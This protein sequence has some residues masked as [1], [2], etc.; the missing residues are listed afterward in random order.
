MPGPFVSSPQ[1]SPLHSLGH[2][3]RGDPLSGR[4]LDN[5]KPGVPGIPNLNLQTSDSFLNRLPVADLEISETSLGKGFAFD[6]QK[7][8][9]PGQFFRRPLVPF[10]D[11][12]KQGNTACH[13][14]FPQ[15]HPQRPAASA[16]GSATG[17]RGGPLLLDE[18]SLPKSKAIS[19]TPPRRDGAYSKL[20]GM[21]SLGG[22]NHVSLVES[23]CQQASDEL[24]TPASESRRRL[25]MAGVPNKRQRDT[26]EDI[27]GKLLSKSTAAEEI[28]GH[29]LVKPPEEIIDDQE[30]SARL[31]NVN[32]SSSGSASREQAVG[33]K[34]PEMHDR[35]IEHLFQRS[36]PAST[37]GD[38]ERPAHRS[39]RRR[40]QP[41]AHGPALLR[42][43]PHFGVLRRNRSQSRTSN[44]SKKRSEDHKHRR[45]TEDERKK[46]AMQHVAQYWN[47]CIQISEDEKKLAN[48]EIGNLQHQLQRQALKLTESRSILSQKQQELESAESQKHQL[49]EEGFRMTEENKRLKD[50]AQTLRGQLS[51]SNAQATK[52]REKHRQIR[53]KLNEAIQEQQTLFR[54]SQA[55][56]EDSMAGFRREK[57]ERN[58]YT[59]KM[60]QALETSRKKREEMKRCFDEFRDKM[61]RESR[62]REDTILQL[63]S[64]IEEQEESL[65]HERN[66]TES[67]RRQADLQRDSQNTMATIS[68]NME[69]FLQDCAM[70]YRDQQGSA[71][72]VEN[73][74]E[75]HYMQN[76]EA[77]KSSPVVVTQAIKCMEELISRRV[78]TVVADLATNQGRMEGTLLALGKNCGIQVQKIREYLEYQN[79]EVLNGQE[80][81]EKVR[82][83]FRSSLES[84]QSE[85][86]AARETCQ[87]IKQAVKDGTQTELALRQEEM[88][89]RQADLDAKLAE[90]DERVGQLEHQLRSLSQ[91]YTKEIAAL[92]EVPSCGEEK[93]QSKLDGVVTEFR[94]SLE[95]GFLQ[96]KSR[97]EEHLRQ[98]QTA[99][100]ALEGQLKAVVDQLAAARSSTP[101]A[102]NV[103]ESQLEQQ[104]QN[105]EK[106]AKA[107]EALRGRW[108]QD[109]KA[110]DALRAQL[111]ELQRRVPQMER[112]DSTL[113][114]MAQMN[115]I[116]HSTAEY[117][118][119]EQDWARQQIDRVTDAD[120]G[121][122]EAQVSDEG[123]PRE[124]K[125]EADFT[126]QVLTFEREVADDAQQGETLFK[127]KVTVYSPAGTVMS[128]SPPP[129]VEQEQVR[130][131][132][133]AQPRSILKL[134]A[135]SS[136]ETGRTEGEKQSQ[137]NR[138]TTGRDSVVEQ[139][140][141]ELL[142]S[143][144]SQLAWSLPSVAD[145]ERDGLGT[146]L[147]RKA[148]N[149]AKRR[150]EDVDD[151]DVRA[152]KKAKSDARRPP[153]GQVGGD[154]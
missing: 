110:V 13:V 68:S 124:A 77:D 52:L 81:V 75:R 32:T 74:S 147:G 12:S 146:L 88:L 106:Q 38:L 148:V 9:R 70:K 22:D 45:R 51:E 152:D 54:R 89:T 121:R 63:R 128:P 6:F 127:R 34:T 101:S 123:Q 31:N 66:V 136:L 79:D 23:P 37:C 142:P 62:L 30:V 100:A 43:S 48:R 104:R 8:P 15:K 47:E 10:S 36:S 125:A 46:K 131:R 94:G 53:D 150:L 97:S 64:R 85:C 44:I 50:E 116:L 33:V 61:E 2:A 87:E 40:H 140:R 113:G 126:S 82:C 153:T 109:I 105:L 119:R 55:F 144:A 59:S 90:R 49:E 103:D 115:E 83:E 134:S 39:P 11:I 76:S 14:E 93:L 7:P 95:K 92:T 151:I 71:R 57:E 4:G 143:K 137:H 28:L 139:I 118:T 56:Y 80:A 67:L 58:S 69:S 145:F 154:A 141:A 72:V 26:N 27:A 130:R 129:S 107:A 120:S 78:V 25:A 21:D 132:G 98:T 114:K 117:L 35:R 29:Q 84:L 91:T 60:D 112:L 108:Q 96:E 135:L 122:H 86:K 19:T 41:A 65:H 5:S 102:D 42:A 24:T 149:R 111:K 20:P 73:I 1:T 133:A 18:L 138:P 3:A 16:V 17:R 99:M